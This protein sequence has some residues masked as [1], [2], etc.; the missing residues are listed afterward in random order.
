MALAE[1]VMDNLHVYNT[2]SNIKHALA[3]LRVGSTLGVRLDSHGSA[4][5]GS[6]RLVAT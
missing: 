6:G 4:S 1:N 3:Q 2:D 5:S